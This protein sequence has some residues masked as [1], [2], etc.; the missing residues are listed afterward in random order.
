[1][2]DSNLQPDRYERPALTIELRA[3]LETPGGVSTRQLGPEGGASP[4]GGPEPQGSRISRST[5]PRRM[6]RK[7]A[8]ISAWRRAVAGSSRR[9][10]QA[11]TA[12]WRTP[13]SWSSAP[14]PSVG[15]I[16][17]V[18]ERLHWIVS[19]Q[20]ARRAGGRPYQ[21]LGVQME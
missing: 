6:A 3:S 15:S 19:V 18:M 17:M 10:P 9:R 11:R 12:A 13:L 4:S 21:H 8:A 2:Q 7:A 14:E 5:R 1:R 16:I 20:G